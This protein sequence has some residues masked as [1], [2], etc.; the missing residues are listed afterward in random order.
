MLQLESKSAM[1]QLES[2][3]AML[4]LEPKSAMLQLE[5]LLMRYC[6]R[7]RMQLSDAKVTQHA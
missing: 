4:Q 7:Y 1:L 5:S 2:K 3:S 6:M